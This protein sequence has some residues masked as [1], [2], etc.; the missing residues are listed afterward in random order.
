MNLPTV[1]FLESNTKQT[2]D[3]TVLVHR[4]V[5]TI[6]TPTAISAVGNAVCNKRSYYDNM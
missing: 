5:V 6:I 3:T 4:I 1:F 2:T